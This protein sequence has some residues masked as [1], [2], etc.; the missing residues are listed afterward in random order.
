LLLSLHLSRLLETGLF[1]EKGVRLLEWP[2]LGELPALLVCRSNFLS[3]IK[4]P[5]FCRRLTINIVSYVF[6]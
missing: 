4:I 3:Q 6:L 2:A 1:E 5:F